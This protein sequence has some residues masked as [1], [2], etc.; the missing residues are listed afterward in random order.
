MLVVDCCVY[1]VFMID[2]S[3]LAYMQ[4]FV[5]NFIQGLYLNISIQGCKTIETINKNKTK[6]VLDM[7][8][9]FS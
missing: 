1:S 7:Q 5:K 3:S 6:H 4:D 2:R 8:P 9:Y